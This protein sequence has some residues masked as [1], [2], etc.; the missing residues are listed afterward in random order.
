MMGLLSGADPSLTGA[1]AV[2]AEEAIEFYDRPILQIQNKK[3][4][5]YAFV[6]L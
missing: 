2:I 1:V 6:G 3:S 5:R 4:A